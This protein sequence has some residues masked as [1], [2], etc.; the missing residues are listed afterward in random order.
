MSR[1]HQLK[2][3][4]EQELAEGFKK[5]CISNGIS[6]AER[7]TQLLEVET[8]AKLVRKGNVFN[9]DTRK[10]RRTTIRE[11]VAMLEAVK[12]RE[13]AYASNIPANLQGGIAYEAAEQA[14][15]AL[16]EAICLLEDAF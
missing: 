13:E 11:I 9:L 8:G 14:I 12:D 16:E 5:R 10:Q 1:T 15:D 2:V 6:M 3:S 7:L 4:I